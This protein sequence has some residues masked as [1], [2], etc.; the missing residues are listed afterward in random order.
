MDW[1]TMQRS[2]Y[3]QIH[4][5][6]TTVPQTVIDD[7]NNAIIDS[8]KQNKNDRY[9]FNHKRGTISTEADKYSYAL[10]PDFLGFLGPVYYTPAGSVQES[11]FALMDATV[12]E[13]EENR[14]AGND[15]NT[16]VQ[17]GRPFKYAVDTVGPS[18]LLAPT[19][20]QDSD[21]IDFRYLADGIIPVAQYNGSAWK[22]YEPNSTTEIG[23]SFTNVWLQNAF[24]LIL[25]RALYL[26]FTGPYG[27]TE[28]SAARVQSEL[29]LWAECKLRLQ[30]ETTGIS[31]KRTVRKYI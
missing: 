7:V 20:S 31:S 8:M 16:Y 18:L 15:F 11:R 26:L 28:E 14:Y 19:P 2:I 29:M 10:P 21:T 9:W 5:D 6:V 30:G 13:I 3:R 22:Y 27:G 24:D 23:T 17:S 25:H 4:Q 12:D 1:Q